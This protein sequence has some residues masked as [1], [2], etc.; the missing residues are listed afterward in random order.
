MDKLRKAGKIERIGPD[1][2]G[3]WKVLGESAVEA[4]RYLRTRLPERP[5][6]KVGEREIR[7]QRR[8]V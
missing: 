2:G 3:H 1:K 7:T 6:T 8:V 4:D 5:M